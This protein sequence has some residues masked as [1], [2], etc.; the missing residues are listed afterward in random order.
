MTGILPFRGRQPRRLYTKENSMTLL[1]RGQL[2]ADIGAIKSS[3]AAYS[4]SIESFFFNNHRKGK[5]DGLAAIVKFWNGTNRRYFVQISKIKSAKKRMSDLGHVASYGN[6][7]EMTNQTACRH[8]CAD[9]EPWKAYERVAC[10][11]S[12]NRKV[13]CVFGE[14]F[15][16]AI[17]LQVDLILRAR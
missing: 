14:I 15:L 4:S 17:H 13:K 5:S 10:I 11:S 16:F 1:D 3:I 9:P 2:I 8:V 6:S 7:L 12:S